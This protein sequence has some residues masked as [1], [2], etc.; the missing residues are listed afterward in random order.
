LLLTVAA[1]EDGGYVMLALESNSDGLTLHDCPGFSGMEGTATFNLRFHNVYADHG[2]ALA[3]PAQFDTFLQR[4]KPGFLISQSGIGLG[5]VQA[6]VKGIEQSNAVK[7]STNR[8]LDESGPQ[9]QLELERTEGQAA[10][11]ARQAAKGNA[12]LLPTLKLRANV[13]ELAL[14]AAQATVLHAG[15]RGYLVR[16]PAQRHWREAVFVAIVTPA[17]KHLRKVIHDLEQAPRQ[18][19]AL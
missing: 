16:H 14:R 11:L 4:I 12:Q 8:F 2:A 13:S 1:L 3:E 10:T 19:A 17:L 7:T 6:C 5:L 9:L 18:V 15:A